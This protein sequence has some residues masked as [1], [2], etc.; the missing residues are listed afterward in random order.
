MDLL[1][2]LELSKFKPKSVSVALR[3]GH[4]PPKLPPT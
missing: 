1:L 2:S 3:R 4:A